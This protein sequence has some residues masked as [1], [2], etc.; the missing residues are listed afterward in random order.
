MKRCGFRDIGCRCGVV[1]G[2]LCV[3]LLAMSGCARAPVTPVNQDPVVDAGPDQ[4]VAAGSTVTLS[5]TATDADG[6]TVTFAWL[7]TSGTAVTL[8][9]ADTATPTF[10]APA[11]AG[12]LIFR[13]TGDDGH[14]GTATDTVTITVTGP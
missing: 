3:S 2:G 9:G 5:G 13:L 14:G 1:L 10:A 8:T 7:Q 11:T 6:D 12:T 4:T